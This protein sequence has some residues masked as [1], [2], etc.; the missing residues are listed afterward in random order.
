MVAVAAGL[1]ACSDG[2]T[3]PSEDLSGVPAAIVVADGDGQV[4]TMG[5]AVPTEPAVVVRN[6]QGQGIAGITVQYAVL[7]GGGTIASASAM[8]DASGVA[9]AGAW[10]LG[11]LPGTNRLQASVGGLAPV[12][13]TA[14]AESPFNIEVRIVGSMSV[15]QRAALDAAVARWQSVITSELI[16]VPL[17]AGAHSCFQGQPQLQHV[18][19]DLLIFAQF[20]SIDGVGGVLGQA[21]PCYIRNDNSLPVMG[22]LQLD[23][24]DL[25]QMELTGTLNDVVL[26]EIGHILGFGTIWGSLG[27]ISGAGS[28]DPAFTGVSAIT[29]YTS[30]G[31]TGATVPVENTGSSGTRDG[32]WRESMLRNELMTGYL[33]ALSNPL[34][35]ITIASLQDMGYAGNVAAASAYDVT[36]IAGTAASIELHGAE[37]MILP[38]YRVDAAG[39]RTRVTS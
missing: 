4:A 22:Y 11:P 27:L 7:E 35:A 16:D 31:G 5:Q 25:A 1:V 14:T 13:L 29:A 18:V 17:S 30:A 2:P 32:H 15:A 36:G 12:T 28:A 3:G 34:S 26:H 9:T 19:D 21:G 33:S 39:V 6:S 8:T 10:T 23:A 38:R 20:D 24:A 37:T